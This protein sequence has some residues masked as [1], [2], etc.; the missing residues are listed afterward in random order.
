MTAESSMDAQLARAVG[1]RKVSA[2]MRLVLAAA[3]S[4][5]AGGQAG[6]LSRFVTQGIDLK[7]AAWLASRHRL[8]PVF[9]TQLLHTPATLPEKVDRSDLAARLQEVAIR[10]LLLTRE[11]IVS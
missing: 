7:K 6:S 3:L 2:E 4:H 10:N 5:L 1:G 9:A 11:M 8:G